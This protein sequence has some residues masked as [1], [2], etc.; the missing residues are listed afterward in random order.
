MIEAIKDFYRCETIGFWL[1]VGVAAFFVTFGV[2]MYVEEKN[3]NAAEAR[4]M[5]ECQE[6][7]KRYEC[8][9]MWRAGNTR[10]HVQPMPIVI[11]MGR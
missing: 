1:I 3:S 7:R 8:E 11:P 4:F 9:A 2:A 6:E 10:T 5:T